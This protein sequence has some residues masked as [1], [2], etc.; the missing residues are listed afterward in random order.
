MVTAGLLISF[1]TRDSVTLTMLKSFIKNIE[2]LNRITGKIIAIAIPG[3]MCLL[4]LE[5]IL[6]YIFNSPTTWAME[7][8]QIL[9]CVFVA[10]GGGYTALQKGH[11]SVDILVSRMT[12]RKRAILDI[13]TAPLFFIFI[14]LFLI[15]MT[16]IAWESM[17]D[18]ETSGT[19]FDPPVYPI[20]I[21]MALGVL[22]LLLHGFSKL[23]EDINLA[24]NRP[25]NNIISQK[26]TSSKESNQ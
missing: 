26:T 25:K 20:K 9:M 16:E 22:L 18:F 8:S 5:V 4:T 2:R 24:I 7:T 13:I 3:I 23:I 21:L 15:K 12:E 11:V 10:L 19:Y 17:Q 14:S 6:R 1:L